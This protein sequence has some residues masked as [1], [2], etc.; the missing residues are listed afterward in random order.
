MGD[1]FRDHVWSFENPTIRFKYCKVNSEIRPIPAKPKVENF[2]MATVLVID[3]SSFQRKIIAGILTE[4]GYRVVL[5]E[6]GKDGIERLDKEQPDLIISDLLMPE[7]DGYW[8]LN[9]L[10]KT[11]RTI[12]IIILTSDIQKTTVMRCR[13]LGV[14]AFLNKPVEKNQLIEAVRKALIRS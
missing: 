12:P 2:I 11:G 10:K 6:N 13:E 1:N 3:D 8:V 4:N 5:S 9:A 7:Y 14:F